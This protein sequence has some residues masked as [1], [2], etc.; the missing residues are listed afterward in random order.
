MASCSELIPASFRQ[1]AQLAA[2]A[3]Q[4]LA[5]P[6]IATHVRPDGDAIGALLACGFIEQGLGHNFALYAPDGIPEYL[7]FLE[8]PGPVYR[9]LAEI[10][11]APQ[12]AI[13]LDLSDPARLG[14]ELAARY[15]D[16]P[17]LNIDHHVCEQG[18]GSVAN[19]IS[20]DAAAA[21]QLVAYAADALGLALA[22]PLGAAIATGI[23]TD[24]GNYTHANISGPIFCLSA[25]LENNGVSIADIGG[26]LRSGWSLN[27]MKLW[28]YLFMRAKQSQHGLIAWSLISE[29]DLTSYGCHAEDLEGY[30]DWLGRL[31]GVQIAFTLRETRERASGGEQVVS[32]LSMR[33]KGEFNARE[34]C[35]ALGGGGHKNASG[36]TLAGPPMQALSQVLQAIEHY[37]A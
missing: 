1:G 10:P 8:K 12:S 32:R 9:S 14:P 26:Q 30:I 34:I 24:T 31:R 16:W 2:D 28:G 20:A 23:L 21:C 3:L 29:D 7:S 15:A 37:L 35:L 36:A 11:F 13:F 27:R 17:S 33:S 5:D 25:E 6:L 19:Y 4:T 22:P 18:L